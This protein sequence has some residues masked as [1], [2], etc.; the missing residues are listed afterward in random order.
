MK[1]STAII[2]LVAWLLPFMAE[3]QVESVR[4]QN[5][6]GESF[7]T[8]VCGV[9]VRNSVDENAAP[10]VEFRLVFLNAVGAPAPLASNATISY[11]ISGTGITNEDYSDSN[12]GEITAQTGLFIQHFSIDIVDDNTPENEETLTVTIT[13]VEGG[14]NSID[15][16]NSASVTIPANDQ[17]FVRLNSC[18]DTGNRV[19]FC[20]SSQHSVEES[21][22]AVFEITFYGNDGTLARLES[23]GT[24]N[25]RIAGDG[26]T[27]D[28]YTDIFMGTITAGTSVQQRIFTIDIDD[29]GIAENAET[30]TVTITSVSGDINLIDPDYT[31]ASVTIPANGGLR[32]YTELL[33]SPAQTEP[34]SGA[35][36]VRYQF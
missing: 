21:S 10:S 35:T 22:A 17:I 20:D 18:R 23:D 33:Q 1:Y 32:I 28:D 16:F 34:A 36:T 19:F 2:V 8:F 14:I 13:S 7:Q 4:I 30:L 6:R 29:D 5:C 15:Q 9:N 25:Y 24:V 11:S 12:N 27:A 3:A 26:I 31:S